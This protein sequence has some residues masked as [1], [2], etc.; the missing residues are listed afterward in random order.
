MVAR[1]AILKGLSPLASTNTMLC[2]NCKRKLPQW[3]TKLKKFKELCLSCEHLQLK[4]I[5]STW[6]EGF[7]SNTQQEIAT[8]NALIDWL[9]KP[10][11]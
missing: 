3:K 6:K 2:Q 10:N 7:V 5:Q 11:G 4:R 9:E 1:L 8:S